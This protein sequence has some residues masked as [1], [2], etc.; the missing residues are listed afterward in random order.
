[1]TAAESQ[2]W[3][4]PPWE[5]AIFSE[6]PFRCNFFPNPQSSAPSN[7]SC[8]SATYLFDYFDPPGSG[9]QCP[10]VQDL[11]NENNAAYICAFGVPVECAYEN[12]LQGGYDPV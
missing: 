5:T 2:F 8:A 7:V 1:M 6:D 12:P 11:N 9:D 3:V 10:S 4:N